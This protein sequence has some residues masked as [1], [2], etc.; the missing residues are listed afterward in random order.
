[1]ISKTKE[2]KEKQYLEEQNKLEFYK[3]KKKSR[4]IYST[5]EESKER[6]L[7][8]WNQLWCFRWWSEYSKVKFVQKKGKWFRCKKALQSTMLKSWLQKVMM[9]INPNCVVILFA[10]R[11]HTHKKKKHSNPSSLH[12]KHR[13]N[14]L[15]Y[16]QYITS[17]WWIIYINLY[18][19]L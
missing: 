13:K 3:K 19:L 5:E 12:Q 16:S 14:L 4:F 11:N 6:K 18:F 9:K 8:W 10:G 7:R 15:R 2:E 17:L 1:M